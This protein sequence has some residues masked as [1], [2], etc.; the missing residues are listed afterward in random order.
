MD[1]SFILKNNENTFPLKLSK[2]FQRRCSLRTKEEEKFFDDDNNYIDYF[3]EIGVKPNIFKEDFLYNSSIDELNQKL[4]P[5]IISQYPYKNKNSIIIDT[6]IINQ[7]FPNGFKILEAKSK[8]DPTSYAI[9]TD[10]QLYSVKYPFK[11]ISCLIIYESISDYRKLYNKYFNKKNND[12]NSYTDFYI[13]KCL[14]I[15]SVHPCIDKFEEIL[16]AIYENIISSQFHN[17]FFNQLINELVIKTPKIPLGYNKV[18][19]KINEKTIDLTEKKIN[20]YPLIHTDLTKL[21]GYFNFNSILDIFKFILYEGN[22]IF[23]SSKI[24][25]LTNSIMSFL[26]LL[27]PFKYQYQVISV[28][29]KDLY[30]YIESD[31]PYIFGINQSYSPNFFTDNKIKLNKKLVC[32]IDLDERK[33]EFIPKNYNTKE[34][35]DFPRH[36]K[37]RVTKNIQDYYKRLI[38][39]ANKGLERTESKKSFKDKKIDDIFLNNNNDKVEEKNEQYQIIFYKFI[40]ELLEEYPKFLKKDIKARN[41]NDIDINDLIDTNAYLNIINTADKEFYIKFFKTKMFKEFILKRVEPKSL[42]EKIDAIFFEEKINERIAEKKMFGKAKI[43]EQNILTS[44]KEY[45]YV[46]EPEII[47]LSVQILP[48][49]VIEVFKDSSYI[50]DFCLINGYDIQENKEKKGDNNN[51]FI[52]NYYIFPNL[53]DYRFY[54]LY[55]NY[56][57]S[58]PLLYQQIDLI[59]SKIIKKTNI[60]FNKKP[61]LKKYYLQNDLYICYIILWS[62]TFWYTDEKEKEYRFKQM[63]FILDKITHQKQETF[64]LLI[65][66]MSVWGATEDDIFYVYIKFLNQKL[67]TNW[68][69]F[70]IIFP[71]LQKKEM[72]TKLNPTAELLKLGKINFKLILSKLSKNKES[73]IKRSLKSRNEWEDMIISNDI[74]YTCF[75]KCIGCGKIID[76]GKICANLSLMHLKNQNGIDMVRCSHKGKDGKSCDYYNCLRLKF[77]YGEELFNPKITKFSSCKNYNVTLLSTCSLKE[78]LFDLSKNYKDSGKKIDID[79]FKK[80]HQLEFW[81]SIW[82]FELND[83]DISFI[84]PYCQTEKVISGNKKQAKDHKVNITND[85]KVIEIERSNFRNKYFPNDLCEQIVYQFA[86]ITNIGMISY[87]NIFI[88]EDNINYNEI[89]IIFENIIYEQN[90]DLE[91]EEPT[92]VRCLTS[93]YLNSY[94][95]DYSDLN[96]SFGN[97]TPLSKKYTNFIGIY[98]QNTSNDNQGF[99]INSASSPMLKTAPNLEKNR[100]SKNF[101]KKEYIKINTKINN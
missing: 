18:F 58:S 54:L 16:N 37:E 93:N 28:L 12:N 53:L 70:N 57:T 80:N 100:S 15:I 59:N 13:P 65:E 36:I 2:A 34:N 74:K 97:N 86:F 24:Y 85:N 92:L 30:Y 62:L 4:N 66:N 84:L 43:I 63:L 29:T 27:S 55:S 75:S 6:R 35:P 50:K 88:Y 68:K 60:K 67:L 61:I 73:F 81:N 77:R 11:Y 9:M 38:A 26:F 89:P 101:I 90:N 56:F 21:F 41:S 64:Q 22:L 17:L 99:L 79:L 25:D 48:I 47:D 71:I 44:S 46:L 39:S 3:I 78:K 87:K 33:Y 40:V 72:D 8:P 91:S 51:I 10:N 82:Y 20:E 42:R 19:L 94:N 95:N 23:F 49:G 32:I 5:K 76:I 14:C 98:R 96:C 69:I 7:V 31:I 45:D 52:F 83:I 1:A